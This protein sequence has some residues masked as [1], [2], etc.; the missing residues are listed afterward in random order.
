MAEKIVYLGCSEKE[1]GQK[2]NK[3]EKFIPRPLIT[4]KLYE[5]KHENVCL[6]FFSGRLF[7]L[8][9]IPHFLIEWDDINHMVFFSVIN[10]KINLRFSF[11]YV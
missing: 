5:E 7:L 8:L 2:L 3:H 11:N 6:C 10:L 4:A 1:R 9:I